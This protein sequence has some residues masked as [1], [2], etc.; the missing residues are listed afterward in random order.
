MSIIQQATC[1]HH[2]VEIQSQEYAFKGFVQV[3]KVS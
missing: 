2:D 3:E 1:T